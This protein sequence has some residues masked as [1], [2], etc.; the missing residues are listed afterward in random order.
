MLRG[1]NFTRVEPSGSERETGPSA[2]VDGFP[3]VEG[4]RQEQ[5]DHQVTITTQEDEHVRNSDHE[6]L[7]QVEQHERTSLTT[8][9]TS[10]VVERS[11]TTH[12]VVDA[13]TGHHSAASSSASD[14]PANHAPSTMVVTSS[15]GTPD[16]EAMT[17]VEVHS[18]TETSSTSIDS[19]VVLNMAGGAGSGVMGG[20]LRSDRPGSLVL[21]NDA[22]PGSFWD[23]RVSDVV[24]D[25]VWKHASPFLKDWWS[26]YPLWLS[27]MMDFSTLMVVGGVVLSCL[28]LAGVEAVGFSPSGTVRHEK[29]KAWV[30]PMVIM[31]SGGG[32]VLHVILVVRNKDRFGSLMVVARDYYEGSRLETVYVRT[33]RPRNR[34]GSE[35]DPAQYSPHFRRYEPYCMAVSTVGHPVFHGDGVEDDDLYRGRSGTTST[36][37]DPD[38]AITQVN[39]SNRGAGGGDSSNDVALRP[40]AIIGIADPQPDSHDLGRGDRRRDED[41]E[42]HANYLNSTRHRRRSRRRRHRSS[43]SSSR[44]HG[45]GSRGRDHGSRG[46]RRRRQRM[47]RRSAAASSANDVNG[48]GTGAAEQSRRST[49][50]THDGHDINH[51]SRRT[52]RSR[53]QRR[54]HSDHERSGRSNLEELGYVQTSDPS[55]RGDRSSRHRRSRQRSRRSAGNLA[56]VTEENQNV[57]GSPSLEVTSARSRDTA[58]NASSWS[59]RVDRDRRSRSR[60]SEDAL[61][62]DSLIGQHHRT[63]DMN[64]RAERSSVISTSTSRSRSTTR[65]ARIQD[66]DQQHQERQTFEEWPDQDFLRRSRVSRHAEGDTLGSST[67]AVPSDGAG[68]AEIPL[69]SANTASQFSTTAPAQSSVHS[70][71]TSLPVPFSQNTSP[72]ST[73]SRTVNIGRTIMASP[74]VLG[75]AAKSVA[76]LPIGAARMICAR[77]T[78]TPGRDRVDQREDQETASS[79]N[80]S[81]HERGSSRSSSSGSTARHSRSSRSTTSAASVVRTEDDELY[82]QSSARTRSN[83]SRS[84]RAS[85]SDS[86]SGG[87]TIDTDWHHRIENRTVGAESLATQ[88]TSNPD[89]IA[90]LDGMSRLESISRLDMPRSPQPSVFGDGGS[91]PGDRL[92]I[93]NR[94][95][96]TL[97]GAHTSSVPLAAAEPQQHQD[98]EN[99]QSLENNNNPDNDATSTSRDHEVVDEDDDE[100]EDW[101]MVNSFALSSPSPT[102]VGRNPSSP[103]TTPTSRG[104]ASTLVGATTPTPSSPTSALN[105]QRS[106]LFSSTRPSVSRNLGS[107]GTSSVSMASA[108]AD[109]HSVV[110]NTASPT[111][112]SSTRLRPTPVL[113]PGEQIDT[114]ENHQHENEIME[115]DRIPSRITGGAPPAHLTSSSSNRDHRDAHSN[116]SPTSSSRR[117]SRSPSRSTSPT[118]RGG[119]G[120][121]SS[122]NGIFSEGDDT[123]GASGTPG[124]EVVEVQV[125]TGEVLAQLSPHDMF[126]VRVVAPRIGANI[127]PSWP[128]GTKGPSE[129]L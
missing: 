50:S 123:G 114:S 117:R 4:E 127:A 26:E 12:G 82:G 103:R 116:P 42:D 73:T 27:L 118:N 17:S 24:P 3:A 22:P 126:G 120:T 80:D 63:V 1:P 109:Q 38:A 85:S 36:S 74:E 62:S 83:S 93:S 111:S 113:L 23:A 48:E 58:G 11:E 112:R 125:A 37:S 66:V 10:N 5:W 70:T 84:S 30:L 107:R 31:L 34:D 49:S 55:G 89:S 18:I 67:R 32:I 121:S 65:R 43:S 41:D 78:G 28:F 94:T 6:S 57:D 51:R 29:Q 2:S 46:H 88:P 129:L 122:S 16:A 77:A 71:P 104:P 53:E 39:S 59:R 35:M 95:L 7:A 68:V 75:R 33:V 52:R 9:N 128:P 13:P 20:A 19:S 108:G 56:N 98:T 86:S 44:R 119:R 124:P 14:E 21:H 47:S 100:N 97:G 76:Q 45:H 54:R 87:S 101:S 15:A 115:A 92:S 96:P 61:A 99:H 72:S 91:L 79:S 64:S 90:R 60:D 40:R 105:Y 106:S 8:M 81:E 69:D 25:S 110:N 102:N